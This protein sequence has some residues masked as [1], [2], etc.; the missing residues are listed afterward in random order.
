MTPAFVGLITATAFAVISVSIASI[1]SFI[2]RESPTWVR[3]LAG[4]FLMS[5]PLA[6]VFAAFLV[7][8]LGR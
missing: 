4:S 6:G 5:A 3:V 7:W 2:E 8:R 1:E